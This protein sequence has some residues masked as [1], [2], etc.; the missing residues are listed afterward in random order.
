MSAGYVHVN[1]VSGTAPPLPA[2][3]QGWELPRLTCYLPWVPQDTL[4]SWQR[5]VSSCQAALR[6]GKRVVIDNTNPDV[7]S[8]ARYWKLM[9]GSGS[10]ACTRGTLRVLGEHCTY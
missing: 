3:V 4:G 9:V 5:C 10:T 7:P 1:R 6:Q 2:T 8:R